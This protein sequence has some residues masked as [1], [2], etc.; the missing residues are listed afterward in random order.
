[1]ITCGCIELK[2][3]SNGANLL[4][5]HLKIAI[6]LSYRYELD[7]R[8]HNVYAGIP[9]VEGVHDRALKE[10]ETFRKNLYMSYEGS[11]RV[12]DVNS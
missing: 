9:G 12:F 7:G 11:K 2:K 10:R 4:K 8:N 6:Y 1:M 3:L 5:K